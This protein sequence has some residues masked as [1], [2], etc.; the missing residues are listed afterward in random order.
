MTP[1]TQ[2]TDA[3][4]FRPPTQHVD[5]V[6]TSAT[7]LNASFEKAKCAIAAA[8]RANLASRIDIIAVEEAQFTAQKQLSRPDNM[9]DPVLYRG[10]AAVDNLAK[11][12][13]KYA[14]TKPG[15]A[16]QIQLLQSVEASRAEV[17]WEGEQTPLP[18]M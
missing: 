11:N 8:A 3:E 5:A 10:F 17:L 9:A 1:S 4:E 6:S 12:L 18:W 15:P 16:Q 2:D 14:S 7:H 13:K